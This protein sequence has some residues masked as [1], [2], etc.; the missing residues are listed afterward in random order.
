MDTDTVSIDNAY[1]V[2]ICSDT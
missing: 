2:L 1:L